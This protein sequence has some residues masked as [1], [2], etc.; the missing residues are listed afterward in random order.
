MNERPDSEAGFYWQ[1]A[2]LE[3]SPLGGICIGQSQPMRLGDNEEL[4]RDQPIRAASV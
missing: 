3:C 1:W 4:L 2:V